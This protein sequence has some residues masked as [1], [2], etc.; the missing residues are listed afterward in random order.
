MDFWAAGGFP[1]L[2]RFF[3]V[4]WGEILPSLGNLGKRIGAFGVGGT[5][6]SSLSP[7]PA[8]AGE[9]RFGG[10]DGRLFVMSRG[11]SA[12]LDAGTAAEAQDSQ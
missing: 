3:L 7:S 6:A 8:S 12:G 5:V 4:S 9:G 2:H 11:R 10:A 1:S